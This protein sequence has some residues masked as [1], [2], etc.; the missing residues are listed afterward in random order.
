VSLSGR[1]NLADALAAFVI[2]AAIQFSVRPLA[3]S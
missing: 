2:L 1:E 3:R